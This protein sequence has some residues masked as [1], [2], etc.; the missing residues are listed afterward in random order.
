MLHAF[1]YVMVLD[2]GTLEKL[3]GAAGRHKT[4]FQK[5]FKGYPGLFVD[6]SY[7]APDF[8]ALAQPQRETI[9]KKIQEMLVETLP[10]TFG[11][12]GLIP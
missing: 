8:D 2:G 11:D 12:L 7:W 3:A 9:S 4:R 6:A 5:R 10:D 1:F